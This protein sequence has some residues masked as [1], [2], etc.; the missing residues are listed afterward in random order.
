MPFG[1]ARP[2]AHERNLGITIGAEL[3]AGN[4]AGTFSF[5]LPRCFPT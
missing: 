5:D 3:F 2:F 4:A 1:V